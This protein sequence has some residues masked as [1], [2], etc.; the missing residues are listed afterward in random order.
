MNV[1]KYDKYISSRSYKV[2]LVIVLE[3]LEIRLNEVDISA[4]AS[5]SEPS[6]MCLLLVE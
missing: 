5:E 2:F 1:Y 6:E 4:A 3:S